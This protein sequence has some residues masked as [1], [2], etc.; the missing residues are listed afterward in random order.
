MLCGA[1][2]GGDRACTDVCAC[3]HTHTHK[4]THTQTHTHTCAHTQAN[5]LV[6]THAHMHI[7]IYKHKRICTHTYESTRTQTRFPHL[8]SPKLPPHSVYAPRANLC[9]AR[10]AHT[11]LATPPQ[12]RV[13][14]CRAPPPH[15]T[16]SVVQQ[17]TL[18]A[19]A[20]VGGQGD[21]ECGQKVRAGLPHVCEEARAT[22]WRRG[23]R[24][25]LA[26]VRACELL[27]HACALEGGVSSSSHCPLGLAWCGRGW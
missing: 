4:H 24:G 20:G 18:D 27:Q 26:C 3:M 11:L 10:P 16:Q 8:R 12:A 15:A 22:V 21:G 25:S 9:A 6:H 2:K 23:L 1:R 5:T 7:C 19:S 17:R 14:P 13:Q